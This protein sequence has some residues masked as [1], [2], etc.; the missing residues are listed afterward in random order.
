MVTFVSV[1]KRQPAQEESLGEQVYP[2]AV[3]KGNPKQ[4]TEFSGKHHFRIELGKI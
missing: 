3:N 4:K 1:W 2:Y